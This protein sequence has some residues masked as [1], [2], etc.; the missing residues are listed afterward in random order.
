RPVMYIYDPAE[1]G[2][3]AN[4][5]YP[6]TYSLNV[7]EIFDLTTTGTVEAWGTLGPADYVHPYFVGAHYDPTTNLLFVM[8]Q[9]ADYLGGS[10]LPS[11]AACRR[12][13][14]S[15][16]TAYSD[17]GGAGGGAPPTAP[18]VPASPPPGGQNPVAIGQPP[19]R[20][21]WRRRR[22]LDSG[23]PCSAF[24]PCALASA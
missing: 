9:D 12:G 13:R 15:T 10:S 16:S 17:T 6:H 24:R 19:R 7:A 1:L 4:G 23:L 3:V 14:W 11:G 18:G 2:K 20:R 8:A 21:A 22:S 5:T